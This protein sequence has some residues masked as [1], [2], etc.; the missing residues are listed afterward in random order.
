MRAYAKLL[1][2]SKAGVPVVKKGLSRTR[3]GTLKKF[4]IK[5]NQTFKNYKFEYGKTGTEKIH[6]KQSGSVILQLRNIEN[7]EKYLLFYHE[8]GYM[9]SEIAEKKLLP[10]L[11][12]VLP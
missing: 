6:G 10:F 2:G 9:A 11:N 12:D 4:Y 8:K 3:Y 7:G 1:A 5:F